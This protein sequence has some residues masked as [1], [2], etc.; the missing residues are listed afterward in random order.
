MSTI[1]ITGAN[2]GIGL[3]F[4]RQ[5]AAEGWRVHAACR[6]PDKAAELKVVKGDVRLHRLDVT[7]EGQI[8]ALEAAL[9]G[10]PIDILINNAGV[11]GM[12]DSFGGTEVA[13]WLETL[14]VNAIAPVRVSEGLITNLERGH[15]K[16]IVN[17]TSR[18]G[19]V[20]ENSSGGSYAYRSS[21]AA[22]NMAAKSMSVDLKGRGITVVVFHPGWVQTDMGGSGAPVTPPESVAG[23]RAK[24]AKLTAADSGH[25]FNYTGQPI[26]W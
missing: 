2:R 25:F 20:A 7:D 15:R 10:E 13:G 16:L 8:D 26:P 24:I 17:I 19:S 22:L 6:D 5:Y 23:M 18:L 11:R 4:V 21:K 3:E 1:L 9:A 14:R 12:G